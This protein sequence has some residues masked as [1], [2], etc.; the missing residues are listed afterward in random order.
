M[1]FRQSLRILL[2]LKN[3]SRYNSINKDLSGQFENIG[4]LYTLTAYQIK[5]LLESLKNPNFNKIFPIDTLKRKRNLIIQAKSFD[6]IEIGN[7]IV[8][9]V[10]YPLL[11]L[12]FNKI[13]VIGLFAIIREFI[14]LSIKIKKN[15]NKL[16]SSFILRL[17][18][19]YL[20]LDIFTTISGVKTYPLEFY[21]PKMSRQFSTN[22]IHYSQNSLEIKFED[23]NIKPNNSIVDKE[24]LGDIH[25]VWTT[26]YAEYLQGFNSNIEFRAVGSLV[27]K[28]PVKRLNL[29]KKNIITIFDVSPVAPTH[30]Q[31][32]YTDILMK[33]FISDIID[34]YE[35]NNS[36]KDFQINLKSKRQ[37]NEEHHSVS[38]INFLDQLQDL[39]KIIIN[40]WDTD[41]Y[42]L[43]A[44]SKL[45]ISIP[46]TTI[47]CIG[48]EMG[49][50]SVFYYPYLRRLCN[51]IYED[52]IQIIYGRD[53]LQ[54]FIL[55]NLV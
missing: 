28:I 44:E 31:E 3:I 5:D 23:E 52:S 43:V 13:K 12:I 25:W 46:F 11:F 21:F 10:P 42:T 40:H 34:V 50:K 18:N 2:H 7:T 16:I 24:S 14:E 17:L 49:T 37:L 6:K 36:L 1:T 19:S 53:Q 22:V 48:E 20:S 45:I 39:N 9:L 38:Y 41:P 33:K 4:V 27:F 26:R 30:R 29:E 8:I 32:F 54:K 55:E 15:P 47:S 35:N 51:P